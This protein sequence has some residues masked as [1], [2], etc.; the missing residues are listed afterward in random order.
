MFENGKKVTL[1]RLEEVFKTLP[2][3]QQKEF[4]KYSKEAG[5]DFFK[6][7]LPRCLNALNGIF[8]FS[9]VYKIYPMD[10]IQLIKSN[11]ILEKMTEIE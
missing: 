5:E 2:K 10:V 8:E 1:E 4:I 9:S 11:N 3:K 6:D 7:T